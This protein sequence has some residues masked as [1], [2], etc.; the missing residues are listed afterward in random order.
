MREKRKKCDPAEAEATRRLSGR[1][2]KA[3]S[4]TEINCSVESDPN[5]LMYP[6]CSPLDWIDVVMS[7]AL[8]NRS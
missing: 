7:Q 4:C 5:Y 6:V 2:R 3:K 8:L 1:P